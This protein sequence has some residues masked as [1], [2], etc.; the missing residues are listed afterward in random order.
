[1][2]KLRKDVSKITVS[3]YELNGQS[4][5][6][7]FVSG[8]GIGDPILY[9]TLAFNRN[10]EKFLVSKSKE[11]K[12]REN[13]LHTYLI[14]RG[15]YLHRGNFYPAKT[16]VQDNYCLYPEEICYLLLDFFEDEDI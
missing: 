13:G 2:L 6:T 15:C 3:V 9:E 5:Y 12:M 14:E 10:Q 1:M 16:Q 4:L 8:H 11:R 7:V